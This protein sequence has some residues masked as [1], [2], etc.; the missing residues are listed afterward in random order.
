MSGWTTQQVN[1]F[2]GP[3]R[4]QL[5]IIKCHA[6]IVPGN[7]NTDPNVVLLN[8]NIVPGHWSEEEAINLF[9][10]AKAIVKAHMDASPA[11]W[12][13]Y[14]TNLSLVEAQRFVDALRIFRRLSNRHELF[15]GYPRSI[16]NVVYSFLMNR[17]TL[18][19]SRTLPV[20]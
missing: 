5:S 2:Q 16:L 3:E 1:H 10:A 13:H 8:P 14:I 17:V 11:D 4:F 9:L 19:R 18:R 15:I 12:E 20:G 6:I 7:F